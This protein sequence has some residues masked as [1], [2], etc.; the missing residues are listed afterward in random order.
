MRQKVYVWTY[1]FGFIW[2]F[3]L[4]F[5]YRLLKI[6]P[7]AHTL[8]LS[9]RWTFSSQLLDWFLNY[10][11]KKGYSHTFRLDPPNYTMTTDQ[12]MLKLVMPGS[13]LRDFA[14]LLTVKQPT[15]LRQASLPFTWLWWGMVIPTHF[16]LEGS[17]AGS[18]QRDGNGYSTLRP[19]GLGAVIVFQSSGLPMQSTSK[20]ALQAQS[21]W[22]GIGA[23]LRN[24]L[25]FSHHQPRK[26]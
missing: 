8:T 19:L 6:S 13:S 17:K 11:K 24:S 23:Q 21:S 26:Y 22:P 7:E 16:S 20:Q 5:P 1:Y 15:Y 25:C 12:A 9:S 10:R 18:T 2:E 14:S 3:K 4:Y